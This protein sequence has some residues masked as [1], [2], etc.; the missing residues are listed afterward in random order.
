MFTDI[1][2]EENNTFETGL[3]LSK[4]NKCLISE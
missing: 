2:E 3:Y 4:E 1:S